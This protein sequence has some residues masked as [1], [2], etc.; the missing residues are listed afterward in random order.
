M[1][2]PFKSF[3]TMMK[4]SFHIYAVNSSGEKLTGEIV[5]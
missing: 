2:F 1:L 3:K 5:V 4:F